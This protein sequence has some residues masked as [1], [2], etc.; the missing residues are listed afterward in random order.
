VQLNDDQRAALE[1]VR[2][3]A[4]TAA[5]GLDANCPRS[6]PVELD[7]K[8]DTLRD[9]LSLLADAFSELRPAVVQFYALLDDEQKGRI[10]AMSL[11][12]STAPGQTGT[13]MRPAAGSGA[14]PPTGPI[15]TRWG[16]ILMTWP[17]KQIDAGMKLSFGQRAALYELSAAIY[18][19]V[20][21]L[22]DACPGD[23]AATA[24][25]RLDARHAELQAVR[26][27]IEAIR[28]STI[29]FEN[30]LNDAQKKQLAEAMGS[31]THTRGQQAEE[32][33]A[34]SLVDNGGH[35]GETK[36]GAREGRPGRGRSPWLG[37][38]FV[39]HWHRY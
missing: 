19:S 18:R 1:Q 24:L 12:G 17:V 8:L 33:L 26:Q 13:R 25:G 7:A 34:R 27:D 6:I 30:A 20:E 23:N 35:R 38:A 4:G 14:E 21:H 3:S 16:T 39:P 37:I 36:I 15:C 11:S 2:T 9:A 29:A 28:P 22:V 31:G 32:L 5:Q 10:L